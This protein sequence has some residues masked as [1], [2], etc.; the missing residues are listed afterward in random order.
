MYRKNFK[1]LKKVPSNAGITSFLS[2]H[3]NE[4]FTNF[5]RKW[6]NL[7]RVRRNSTSGNLKEIDM[8]VLKSID[9]EDNESY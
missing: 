8:L 4:N 6:L 1:Y 9:W 3:I 7:S 2:S 5:N